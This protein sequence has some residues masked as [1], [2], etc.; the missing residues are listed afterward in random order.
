MSPRLRHC[1]LALAA[2]LAVAFGVWYALP[3]SGPPPGALAFCDEDGL[4]V[5]AEPGAGFYGLEGKSGRRWS[6]SGAEAKL[7]LRRLG[8]PAISQPIRLR[9]NLHSLTPRVVTI[10]HDTFVLWKGR[11]DRSTV[12][13]DIAAFTMTAP[14]QEI[15]LVSDLPGEL[16]PGGTDSRPLAFAVYDLDI[17][18]AN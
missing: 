16:A 13:V 18:P 12:P 11:L 15:T 2:G 6:W 1:V 5:V 4:L 8:H 14:V 17:S 9:F 3:A 10:S 7:R